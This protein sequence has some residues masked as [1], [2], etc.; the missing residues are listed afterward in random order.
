MPAQSPAGPL[1]REHH[2]VLRVVKLL[3]SELG[4]M[5][6]DQVVNPRTLDRYVDFLQTYG[7]RCHH[8]KEEDILFSLLATKHL[9]TDLAEMMEGLLKDHARA[10]V[11]T[12]TLAAGDDR[13][14]SG[15]A[16]GMADVISAASELVELYPAHINTEERYFFKPS[17][18]YC[19]DAERA[20][21][22]L[23]YDEFD[24][25]LIHDKYRDVV[26]AL[27]GGQPSSSPPLSD[28]PMQP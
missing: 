14:A 13:F 26:A 8:G 27:E 1:I 11:L 28:R 4:S 3:G 6:E 5:R 12:T 24:R 18:E 7:D 2:L 9:T 16:G 19:S 25:A 17:L 23:D 21:M 20:Q 15:D 10:R 22:L